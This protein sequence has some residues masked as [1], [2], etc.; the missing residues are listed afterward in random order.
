MNKIELT[1]IEIRKRLFFAAARKG[2]S[3]AHGFQWC[4]NC[5]GSGE[6]CVEHQRD[7]QA[8][9]VFELC[10]QCHGEKLV[11]IVAEN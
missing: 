2:V 4:G 5:R 6:I 7:S 3:Q 11:A 8:W 10:P 1:K 9:A